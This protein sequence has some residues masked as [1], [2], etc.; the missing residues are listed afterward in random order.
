MKVALAETKAARQACFD[1]RRAVFIEEQQ[2]PEA[3]EWDA[4]D[5]SC[6]HYLA[7]DASGAAAGTARVIARGESAKIGRVAVLPAHR[8]TGLGAMIM[9]ALMADAKKRGFSQA[10][11]E[12]Q[13]YAIPFY[14]RLGFVAEGPDYDDGSGIMHRLMRAS[15]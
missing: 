7:T 1:I 4:H 10:E 3:E 11:L 15:L 14:G 6:L 2:I 13:V 9:R 8:G 12:S 5:A